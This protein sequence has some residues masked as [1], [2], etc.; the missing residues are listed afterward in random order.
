M[1]S[2]NENHL[3]NEN[4]SPPNQNPNEDSNKTPDYIDWSSCEDNE[5]S[6]R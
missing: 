3:N 2:P 6:S 5:D 4:I 1:S